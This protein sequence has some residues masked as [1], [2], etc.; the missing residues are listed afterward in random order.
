[1]TDESTSAHFLTTIRALTKR[2]LASVF[3][4]LLMRLDPMFRR[5]LLPRLYPLF[6]VIRCDTARDRAL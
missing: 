4:G 5:A 1:M 6:V 2:I 3:R